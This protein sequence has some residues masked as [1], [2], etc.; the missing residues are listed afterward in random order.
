MVS[1]FER[2]TVWL[3]DYI[4]LFMSLARYDFVVIQIFL[5]TVLDDVWVLCKSDLYF[6]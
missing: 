4:I 6:N 2:R 5:S 1:F 3:W